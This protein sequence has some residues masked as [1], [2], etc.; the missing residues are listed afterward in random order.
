ATLRFPLSLTESAIPSTSRYFSWASTP[1]CDIR[2]RRPRVTPT[3][4]RFGLIL[5][6]FVG[7]RGGILRIGAPGNS[8]LLQHRNG[9]PNWHRRPDGRRALLHLRR[10]PRR[11]AQPLPLNE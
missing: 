3:N 2:S 9:V 7:E 8:L 1:A 6:G 5:L 10:D 11:G 4:D